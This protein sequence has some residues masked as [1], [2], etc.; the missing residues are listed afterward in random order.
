MREPQQV[1]GV[2]ALELAMREVLDNMADLT[3]GFAFEAFG[4]DFEILSIE[5]PETDEH[6]KPAAEQT[7]FPSEGPHLVFSRERHVA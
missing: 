7:S 6:L 1:N 4:A 5:P 2:T 3:N